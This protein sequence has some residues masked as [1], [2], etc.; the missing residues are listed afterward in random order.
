MSDI[1]DQNTRSRMMANIKAKNTKPEVAIRSALHRKGYRFRT[2][3]KDLPGRPD[4][5]LPKHCAVVFVNG[6]FW[7][8]HSCSLFK[9]PKTRVCFWQQ[10]I[11]SNKERDRRNINKLREIGW[12]VCTVWECSTRNQKED[13]FARVID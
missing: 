5:V 1:V 7:H 11:L 13:E 8:G 4:I 12:R 6:C 9:W 3:R 10:K 2:H